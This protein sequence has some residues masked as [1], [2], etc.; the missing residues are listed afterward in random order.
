MPFS[1]NDKNINIQGR[2]KGTPNTNTKDLKFLIGCLFY[3]NL[4]QVI[5]HEESLNITQRLNLNKTLLPYVLPIQKDIETFDEF[6][7]KIMEAKR[8]KNNEIQS[9]L[10]QENII[11]KYSKNITNG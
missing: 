9:K 6:V 3:Y 1:K 5:E 7:S 11:S 2:K 10:E 8:Q 4:E